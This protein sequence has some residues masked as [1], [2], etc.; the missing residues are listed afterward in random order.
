MSLPQ[1][2]NNPKAQSG[3]TFF[4]FEPR[5]HG[6]RFELPLTRAEMMIDVV[7]LALVSSNDSR[8]NNLQ[9]ALSETFNAACLADI[10]RS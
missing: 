6:P 2:N 9:P 8:Q 10:Q 5:A 4:S 3:V 7:Y 1:N